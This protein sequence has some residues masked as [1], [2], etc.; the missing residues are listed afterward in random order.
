MLILK[1]AA[2]QMRQNG[3]YFASGNGTE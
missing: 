1:I 2:L 3:A